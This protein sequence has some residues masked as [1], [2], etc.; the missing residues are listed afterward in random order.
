M[1][2]CAYGNV[3]RGRDR[4]AD[5]GPVVAECK[6]PTPQSGVGGAG[7]L[8]AR[9]PPTTE[10]KRADPGMAGDAPEPAKRQLGRPPTPPPEERTQ[11]TSFPEEFPPSKP[12]MA[13]YLQSS[14][15]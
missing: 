15:I 2:A 14:H 8:T 13:S 4:K 10:A 7:P 3:H 6:C 11:G 12:I 5:D 1:Y 9:P